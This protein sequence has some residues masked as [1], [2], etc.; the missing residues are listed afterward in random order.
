MVTADAPQLLTIEQAMMRLSV[1]RATVY[2]LL[3]DGTLSS[4]HV[5]GRSRRIPSDAIDAYIRG[6]I[7]DQQA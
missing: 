1:S 6:L 3:G 2:R 5:R 4:V 7:Q